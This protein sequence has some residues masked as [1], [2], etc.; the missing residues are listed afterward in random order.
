MYK[1]CIKCKKDLHLVEFNSNPRSADKKAYRCKKCQSEDNTNQY[2]AHIEKRKKYSKEYEKIRRN[3]P[4]NYKVKKNK[5]LK[6]KK[7]GITEDKYREMV[8][9]QN[10]LCKICKEMTSTISHGK[11]VIDHCH[12]TG[13]VRGLLCGSC[14]VMLGN[15]KD[16]I[17]ILKSAIDYLTG[18][19][20][21]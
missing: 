20:S 1:K 12:K 3:R 15:A 14:N 17:K 4:T 13:V 5:A 10:N 18:D 8:L 7:Y 6:Y 9:N 16:S 19:E 21:I 2:V 11:L